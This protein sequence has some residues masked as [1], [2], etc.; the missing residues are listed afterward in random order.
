LFAGYYIALLA[1]VA[2]LHY[3]AGNP[4]PIP[5]ILE[6][7]ILA[8]L[9]FGLALLLPYNFFANFIL[10]KISSV[11][12]DKDMPPEKFKPLLRK[13]ILFLLIGFALMVLLPWSIDRLLPPFN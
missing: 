8:Q 7:N 2:I 1:L 11:P 4:I 10:K 3:K 6:K 12:I 5:L 9:A 13:S